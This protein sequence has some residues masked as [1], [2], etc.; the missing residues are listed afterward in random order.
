[1]VYLEHRVSGVKLKDKTALLLSDPRKKTDM[2]DKIL[3]RN[4][5]HVHLFLGLTCDQMARF[6]YS[7]V[8]ISQHASLCH[9][10]LTTGR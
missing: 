1:M 6:L 2:E 5:F 4:H 3:Y 7:T 10:Q 8:E 9:N